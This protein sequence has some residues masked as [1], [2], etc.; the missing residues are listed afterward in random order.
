[1]KKVKRLL[2]KVTLGYLNGL[3]EIYKPALDAGINPFL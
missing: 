2:K 1:M 3:M